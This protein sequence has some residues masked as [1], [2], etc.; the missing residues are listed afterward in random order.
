VSTD[1]IQS[2]IANSEVRKFRF[3]LVQNTS[4]FRTL[5]GDLLENG[6]MSPFVAPVADSTVAMLAEKGISYETKFENRDFSRLNMTRAGWLAERLLNP[7]C[8]FILVA[9]A[10]TLLRG[11]HNRESGPHSITDQRNE[12]R[13]DK[14][15]AALAACGMIA[16]AVFRGVATDWKVRTIATSQVPAIVAQ[17]KNARFDVYEYMDGSRKLWISDLRSPDFIAPANR[18]TLGVLTQENIQYQTYVAGMAG[19][20]GPSRCISA[21]WILVLTAGAGSLLGWVAKSRPVSQSRIQVP[22]TI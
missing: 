5:S 21:L 4:G 18:S 22:R 20:P 6:K 3:R 12:R 15:F 19:L 11:S 8:C 14:S 13:V 16:L 1:E 17:H 9:G 7:F 2:L 10:V